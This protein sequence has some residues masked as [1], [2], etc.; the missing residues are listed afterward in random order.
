MYV[1]PVSIKPALIG[2]SRNP[3]ASDKAMIAEWRDVEA[4]QLCEPVWFPEQPLR[5]ADVQFSV[6]NANSAMTIQGGNDL[7]AGK[8]KPLN[9]VLGTQ[10]VLND[11]GVVWLLEHTAYI[12]PIVTGPGTIATIWLLFY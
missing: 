5:S 8:P 1:V 4:G 10:A 6:L 7:S 3:K 12:Q 2:S 11:D 9:N